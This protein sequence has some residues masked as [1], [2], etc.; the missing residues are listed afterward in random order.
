MLGKWRR[1]HYCH[2]GPG[3]WHCG[4]PHQQQLLL[5]DHLEMAEVVQHL[6]HLQMILQWQ[7]LLMRFACAM[8]M[9]LCRLR[10]DM[11]I[12]VFGQYLSLC[13]HAGVA[14]AMCRC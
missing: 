9:G 10:A 5:C 1:A 12:C 2:I 11:P 14:A 6:S 3:R 8:P 7:L 4:H 13:V